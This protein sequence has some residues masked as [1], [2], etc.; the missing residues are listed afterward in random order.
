M[1]YLVRDPGTGVRKVARWQTFPAVM[2]YVIRNACRSLGISRSGFYAYRIRIPSNR[3]LENELLSGK[4]R[5]LFEQ[6]SGRY[7]AKRITHCLKDEGIKINR[8]RVAKLMRAMGLLAKGARR[9]YKNC[10]RQHTHHAGPNLIQQDGIAIHRNEVWLGD[11]LNYDRAAGSG[12]LSHAVA[13]QR[14]NSLEQQ[15]KQ[16]VRLCLHG[17]I[18]Q[19]IEAPAGA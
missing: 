9:A 4:I 1:A 12:Y 15:E 18:L 13:K 19:E 7:G 14:S 6:H 2:Q 8:K 17:I 16:S 3:Q 5:T 11:I 10:Q